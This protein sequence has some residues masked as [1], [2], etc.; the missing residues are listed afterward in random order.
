MNELVYLYGDLACSL[1][2][3]V[4]A[5]WLLTDPHFR[6]LLRV[7][8]ACV[9]AGALVNVLGILADQVGFE[10]ISYGRVW[11]GELVVNVGVS[12]LMVSWMRHSQRRRRE[13]RLA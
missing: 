13:A 4:C 6:R 3:M 2:M 12:V 8:H 10:G 5:C 11:P 1:V 9:A 7:C